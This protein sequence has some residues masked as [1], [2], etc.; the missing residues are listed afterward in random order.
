[1]KSGKSTCRLVLLCPFYDPWKGDGTSKYLR[2]KVPN[3]FRRAG[4]THAHRW[5]HILTDLVVKNWASL[6]NAEV[7]ERKKK[8]NNSVSKRSFTHHSILFLAIPIRVSYKTL[9][10]NDHILTKWHNINTTVN[11][12]I[13]NHSTN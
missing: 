4:I 5:K 12:E 13:S 3:F 9:Q 2:Y 6:E 10:K 8:T 7:H 1:M 11:T